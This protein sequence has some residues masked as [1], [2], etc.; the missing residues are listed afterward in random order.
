MVSSRIVVAG[1]LCSCLVTPTFA[2]RPRDNDQGSVPARLST[3]HNR[4]VEESIN[5]F[6]DSG[7]LTPLQELTAREGLSAFLSSR[8]VGQRVSS[9]LVEPSSFDF[10]PTAAL[11]DATGFNIQSD[12]SLTAM[13]L[14]LNSIGAVICTIGDELLVNGR[15]VLVVSYQGFIGGPARAFSCRMTNSAGYFF[16][17]DRTNVEIPIKMLNA[18][19]GGNPTSHWVF[20]AGLTNFAVEIT[21]FDLFTGIRKTYVNSLGQT[22]NTQIDQL[23]PFPCP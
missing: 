21:A 11:L 20:A 13:P 14:G 16:Y 22:F 5:R 1:L 4:H 15:F 6:V 9:P 23:T 12:D 8:S 2:A 18:C 17:F 7:L 10:E 19:F 3:A